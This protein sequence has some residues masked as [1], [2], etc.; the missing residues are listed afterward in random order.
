MTSSGFVS[1]IERGL[2]GISGLA[3]FYYALV[4]GARAYNPFF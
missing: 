3:L 4:Q 2:L 1:T